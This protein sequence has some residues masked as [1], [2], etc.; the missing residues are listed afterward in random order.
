ME[1]Q[2]RLPAISPSQRIT[3]KH[4]RAGLAGFTGDVADGKNIFSGHVTD[5]SLGGFKVA[6]LPHSFTA[7]RHTY[8][9]ILSGGGKYYRVLAKPCWKKS[10]SLTNRIDIGF[11]ILDAP[12]EWVEFAMN[13]IPSYDYEE[14][15][16]FLA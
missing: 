5:I 14:S 1:Q 13:E 10:G 3:R 6:D 9:A 8:V 11:K 12:W 15:F 7:E 2:P 16:A 4:R